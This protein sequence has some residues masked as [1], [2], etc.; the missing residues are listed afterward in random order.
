MVTNNVFEDL[1]IFD[2]VTALKDQGLNV[3]NEDVKVEN[4]ELPDVSRP[5]FSLL[6][7]LFVFQAEEV[8]WWGQTCDARVC[9]HSEHLE[10]KGI[11][12]FDKLILRI[13]A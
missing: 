1:G 9:Q 2:G 4:L 5:H 12:P 3:L 13:L 11:L 7:S 6:S 8:K 10:V